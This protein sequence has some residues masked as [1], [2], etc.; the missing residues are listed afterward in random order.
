MI[1]IVDKICTNIQ[2][3]MGYYLSNFLAYLQVCVALARSHGY[4]S[5][6]LHAGHSCTVFRILYEQHDLTLL[7]ITT[8]FFACVHG[9]YD[10]I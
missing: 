10:S 3:S 5:L 4:N 2:I 1:S 7:F 6:C 8:S 9:R